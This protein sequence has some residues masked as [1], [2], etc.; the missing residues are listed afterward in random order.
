MTGRERY[1]EGQWY[2]VP[3]RNGRRHRNQEGNQPNIQITKMFVSNLPPRCSSADLV[4]V[5]KGFGDIQGT[6]IARKYDKL[7]KRFG[8]VSFGNVQDP[9]RLESKM[10]DVWIGSYKLFIILARFVDGSKVQRKN[11]KA[12][13]PV[14]EQTTEKSVHGDAEP[15]V[16]VQK[17]GTSYVG[18]RS[19]KDI[20]LGMDPVPEPVEIMVPD[21]MSCCSEGHEVGLL[22]RLVDFKS[23]SNLRVWF[24]LSINKTVTI[25]YLGG[26]NVIVIFESVEDKDWFRMK[27]RLWETVFL[28]LEDWEGQVIDF[29]RLA[30]I[31]VYGIPMC[32]MVESV[33]KDIGA[34]VG[35]VVQASN[36]SDGD[37]WSYVRM[38]VLC[39]AGTRIHHNVQ[40]SWK[41]NVVPVVVEEDPSDWVPG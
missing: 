12:W 30:W 31:K 14:Q 17:P 13:R 25:K 38:G 28:S 41:S 39:K 7:G 34:I 22:G 2:D 33:I 11:E 36:P 35:E 8:F 16:D 5:L 19:F 15:R 20:L 6:Y 9:E 24:S 21:E 27:K 32:L 40:L 23:L 26:L 4:Q 37:D 1:N 3:I 10:K 18:G 29:E